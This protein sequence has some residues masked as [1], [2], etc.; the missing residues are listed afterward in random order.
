MTRNAQLEE[1]GVA[2]L[3]PRMCVLGGDP[4]GGSEVVLWED[5][6]IL[7][8]AG[9]PVRV[10]GR[11]AREGAPVSLI[12][13]RT[14]NAQL[15]SLEYGGQL[16]RRERKALIIAYNEPALAGWAPGR[17]IVRFDWSTPLPR[18]WSWPVWLSRYQR[19]G[20][21]F[22]SESERQIFLRL[23]GSVLA[24][25]TVVVPNAV[26]LQLF[27]PM[28][29]VVAARPTK[30]LR[31]GFAGQWAPGKGIAELLEAWQIVS[32]TLP[33]A[34][35]HMAGGFRLWKGVEL[36]PGA[37]EAAAQVLAMEKQGLLHTTGE[38]QRACMPEFWNSVDIAVNPSLTESFGLVALEAM[39]CGVPVIAT[40]AGGL[41]EIVVDGETG[42]LVRP[43]D[44]RSLAEA[45]LALLTNEPLRLRL[46]E[47][48]WRRAQIFSLER[49]SRELLQLVFERKEKAA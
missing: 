28:N 47:G 30:A 38:L 41:K 21:L 4:C 3:A 32:R 48:A 12:A 18:Y 37:E 39:A 16:L 6:A 25:N 5:A 35:L 7:R 10:Y 23:H 15:N 8:N 29:G 20:Y 40:T 13:L 42:L 27:R 43:G 22:P 34:E 33:S 36:T 2:L 26:D 31:V 1:S 11:A 14:G 45:L 9:I 49:R 44:S 46:A 24:Q 17:T 19:A